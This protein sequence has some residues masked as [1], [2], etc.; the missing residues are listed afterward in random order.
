MICSG[1]KGRPNVRQGIQL[2]IPL[3][4]FKNGLE[5]FS[6]IQK[7]IAKT[8]AVS[9]RVTIRQI[10]TCQTG[11]VTTEEGYDAHLL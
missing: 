1:Q 6:K 11:Q 9:T 3:L 10:W 5:E 2:I 7:H 4:T 8:W